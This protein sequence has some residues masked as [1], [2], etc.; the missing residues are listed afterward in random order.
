MSFKFNA[1]SFKIVSFLRVLFVWYWQW[2]G[3]Q[4]SLFVCLVLLCHHLLPCYRWR[5]FPVTKH[6]CYMFKSRQR[7]VAYVCYYFFC[8]GLKVNMRQFGIFGITNLSP[9]VSLYMYL[10]FTDCHA[11]SIIPQTTHNVTHVLCITVMQCQHAHLDAVIMEQ[12]FRQ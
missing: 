2:Y 3:R 4:G 6:E 1:R 11:P 5:V 8:C 9:L 10:C 7:T 12:M